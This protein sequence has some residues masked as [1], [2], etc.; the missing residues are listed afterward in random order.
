VTVIL[1]ALIPVTV[2]EIVKALCN[3]RG[4]AGPTSNI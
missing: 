1:L 2:I 3:L 4:S